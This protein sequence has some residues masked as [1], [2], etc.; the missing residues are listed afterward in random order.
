MLLHHTEI[1]AEYRRRGGDRFFS[2][3]VH[4]MANHASIVSG[5][6]HSD[7][8]RAGF[9]GLRVAKSFPRKGS[10]TLYREDGATLYLR[11]EGD[12]WTI[13]KAGERR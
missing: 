12:K 11:L 2:D 7:C 8:I 6:P 5:H 4:E 1:A 3:R 10:V 13:T 9:T